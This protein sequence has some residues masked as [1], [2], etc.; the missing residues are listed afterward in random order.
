[1]NNYTQSPQEPPQIISLD[2][3]APDCEIKSIVGEG[4][5]KWYVENYPDIERMQN[6]SFGAFNAL[7]M[8]LMILYVVAVCVR[9]HRLSRYQWTNLAFLFAI[10]L[11]DFIIYFE[12]FQLSIGEL[13]NCHVFDKIFSG[14]IDIF[15]YNITL[16]MGF[17]LYCISND[18]YEFAIHGTLPEKK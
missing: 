8:F 16:R 13:K 4:N 17:K 15:L 5:V 7:M 6:Y 12:Y 11:I 9:K 10:Y 2:A 3:L 18:F 14:T 1:M